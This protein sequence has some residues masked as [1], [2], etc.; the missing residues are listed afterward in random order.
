[1]VN[2]SGAYQ[3]EYRTPTRAAQS[4]VLTKCLLLDTMLTHAESPEDHWRPNPQI[5]VVPSDKLK[6]TEVNR[7][8]PFL[9]PGR[10][11][12]ILAVR[13]CKFGTYRTDL[14]RI[15]AFI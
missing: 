12:A 2:R 5:A 1:M 15:A 3:Y 4:I 6:I 13:P 8:K 7:Q 9:L 10:Y 11:T 14:I